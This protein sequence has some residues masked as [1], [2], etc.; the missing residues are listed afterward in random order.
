MHKGIVLLFIYFGLFSFEIQAQHE[1]YVGLRGGYNTLSASLNHTVLL[2]RE[3]TVQTFGPSGGLIIKYFPRPHLGLQAEFNFTQ[4]GYITQ[5]ADPFDRAK[6]LFNYLELPFMFNVYLGKKKWQ[7]M[8]NMG[9]FV[10]WLLSHKTTG[11]FDEETF[12]NP[13]T[14]YLYDNARDRRLSYGLKVSGGLFR[15]FSFG[16]F[17]VEGHITADLSNFLDP[18]TLDSGIPDNSHHTIY[19]IS[20]AYLFFFGEKLQAVEN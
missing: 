16:A 7:Y 5:F 3:A 11:P 13:R 8:A 4:K 17:Q 6:S 20:V 9:P 18:V 14:T 1:W 15:E 12:M 2:T 10:G 19:G